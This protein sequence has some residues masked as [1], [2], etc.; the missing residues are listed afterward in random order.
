MG[1]QMLRLAFSWGWQEVED[2]SLPQ[3][4]EG[5]RTVF[6]ALLNAENLRVDHQ[7]TQWLKGVVD[8]QG[9]PTI[10]AVGKRGA[11][12]AWLLTQHADMD[13][14]F[15]YHALQLM[16]PLVAEGEVSK[17]NDAYLYD[18]IMLKL[19]GTQR[20]ATQ[21]QCVKGDCVPRPLE[22]PDRMEEYRTQMELSSFS[23]YRTLFPESC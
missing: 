14:A 7:N 16:E 20:Y 2:P 5:E 12:A 23:E 8:E 11:S 4:S 10:S 1:D 9:W 15:Q 3:M 22:D 19:V 18:R 17:R 21:V 6:L 13:P